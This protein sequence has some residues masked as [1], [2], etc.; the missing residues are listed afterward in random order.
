MQVSYSIDL[1][2]IKYIKK[3]FLLIF[4]GIRCELL[5]NLGIEI[6]YEIIFNRIHDNT[7]H[8]VDCIQK[9][10]NDNKMRLNI[11]KTKH[12]YI[13]SKETE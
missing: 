12:M 8:T 4:R 3:Y 13:N 10:A 11:K 6:M 5:K 7:Q 2:M 1:V 9:W